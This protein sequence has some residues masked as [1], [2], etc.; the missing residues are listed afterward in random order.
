MKILEWFAVE[1]VEAT[2][3]THR[4]GGHPGCSGLSRRGLNLETWEIE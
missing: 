2:I 3:H 4:P 1:A